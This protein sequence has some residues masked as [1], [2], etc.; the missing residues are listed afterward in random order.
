MKKYHKTGWL[1]ILGIMFFLMTIMALICYNPQREVKAQTLQEGVISKVYSAV[2][3]DDSFAE[4]G[5]IV[6]LNES[7][8]Q[9]CGID[10]IINDKLKRIENIK[11]VVDLTE[12][13]KE[14]IADDGNISKKKAP[15]LA[16]YYETTAFY[17]IF[18]VDLCEASKENVIAAINRD[19]CF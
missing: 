9:F 4:D 7:N 18:R 10:N 8:S 16:A 12:F 1:H 15:E 2:S 5:L 11:D 13:P 17:Q 19:K 6:I 14:L 3:I